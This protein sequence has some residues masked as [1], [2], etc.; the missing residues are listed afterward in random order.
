MRKRTLI[1]GF[2]GWEKEPDVHVSD[3]SSVNTAVIYALIQSVNIGVVL[4][5]QVTVVSI[6]LR[7]LDQKIC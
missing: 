7:S 2:K 4:E 1:L 5:Q 3:V 6:S